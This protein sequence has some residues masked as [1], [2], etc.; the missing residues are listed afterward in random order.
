MRTM[1]QLPSSFRVS[2]FASVIA[3]SASVTPAVAR[4]QERPP[5]KQEVSELRAQVEALRAEVQALKVIVQ[6]S[7][8]PLAP[9]PDVA[10][11]APAKEADPIVAMLQ[12]QV[13]EQA[14][15]KV[16]SASRLPVKLTGSIVANTFFN[17]GEA[18]W[19]E[20]PNFVN[21]AG[22]TTGSFS[23][24]LR[25]SRIGLSADGPSLGA[26]R[27]S[28]QIAFD[29]LGGTAAFQTGPTIG[30]PRLLYA[31][32][33]FETDR[34]AIEVGQDQA[35]VAPRDPTS[36][37]A[38]AFPA[39]YRSGNLYL[40]A[41]Q[42]RVDRALGGGVSIRAGILA[43]IAGDAAADFVFSPPAGTGERSRMPAFEGRIGF[44]KGPEDARS[45]DI[46]LSGHYGQQH[47]AGDT[48]DSWAAVADWNLQASRFGI[49][50]EV[51]TGRHL[52]AF[53]GAAG[54][55]VESSGGFAELRVRA[56]SRVSF[57]GGGGIDRVP[58]GER[59]GV[60]VGENRT[61]FG[62]MILRLTPEVSTSLEYRYLVTDPN[63]GGDRKNHHIDLALVYTF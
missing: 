15:V 63:Q 11:G 22:A 42:V 8:S 50:G 62:N 30:L 53:G 25:Q 59:F 57:N 60:P 51:F 49:G 39:L 7:G 3:A 56:S 18:N 23:S 44:A 55:N 48:R 4:G 40:R 17:S 2:V 20:N 37:A 33:R 6:G 43:P 19:L 47:L 31:F 38:Q 26:W 32:T 29:F 16:E 13:A 35:I 61:A 24:T 5:T 58:D 14:Q 52:A 21:T 27:T 41:P 54:Q 12:E 28:G 1:L 36:I 9:S 46:G 45:V 34:T 10:A